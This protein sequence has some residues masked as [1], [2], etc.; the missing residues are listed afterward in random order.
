MNDNE[1]RSSMDVREVQWI[2]EQQT[3][4]L[5]RAPVRGPAPGH[6]TV[7]EHDFNSD[8][9]LGAALI[10]NVEDLDREY[11]RDLRTVSQKVLRWSMYLAGI[12]VLFNLLEYSFGMQ[13][14]AESLEEIS[15][16]VPDAHLPD[17]SQII[18]TQIP[19][20]IFGFFVAMII[21]LCG[22]IGAKSQNQSLVCLFC[23]CNFCGAF[24]MILNIFFCVAFLMVMSAAAP[25]IEK[26]LMR[27]DPTVCTD[28]YTGD[29][30]I[31]CLATAM[32][33]LEPPKIP[34]I[35]LERGCPPFLKCQ[36]PTTDLGE[37][38]HWLPK[39]MKH[40]NHPPPS[41]PAQN[42]FPAWALPHDHTHIDPVAKLNPIGHCSPNT[43][44]I[45]AFHNA[46]QLFP[47]LLPKVE[48]MVTLKIVITI[49][50]AFV[51]C[52]AACYGYSLHSKL[53]AGFYLQNPAP[54]ARTHETHPQ[55]EMHNFQR[56]EREQVR[57]G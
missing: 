37:G 44:W 8:S 4:A 5:G 28:R 7:I 13:E 12:T 6:N 57:L 39:F 51:T 35:H 38:R 32:P 22:Y 1:R 25:E 42:G 40:D 54:Y 31:E 55:Q 27:C 43:E 36:K 34:D 30:L 16:V 18:V 15:K 11:E 56:E 41:M 33:G 50:T 2:D 9:N 21:P 17:I 20:L 26:G 46:V 3:A 19:S 23:G 53:S 29:E 49:I 14:V 24:F 48:Q 45:A 10:D 52:F 47:T